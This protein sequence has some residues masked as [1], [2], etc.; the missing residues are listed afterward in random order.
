MRKNLLTLMFTVTFIFLFAGISFAK[1][2]TNSANSTKALNS[3]S[4]A[5]N[6][7]LLMKT[8]VAKHNKLKQFCNASADWNCSSA[9]DHTMA[10]IDAVLGICDTNGYGSQTC[11]DHLRWMEDTVGWAQIVCTVI[12]VKAKPVKIIVNDLEKRGIA[13]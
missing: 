4:A 5:K 12:W 6:N 2:T 8:L 3:L 9:I 10:V 11:G 1:T 13:E 7:I